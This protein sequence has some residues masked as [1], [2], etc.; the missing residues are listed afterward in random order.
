MQ[1]QLF[2]TSQAIHLLIAS[3][4]SIII[5]IWLI[6]VSISSGATQK[7]RSAGSSSLAGELVI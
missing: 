4:I 3:S 2:K 6:V 5:P 7:A 1:I